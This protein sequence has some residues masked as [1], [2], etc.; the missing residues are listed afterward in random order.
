[1]LGGCEIEPEAADLKEWGAGASG[2]EGAEA[3]RGSGGGAEDADSGLL[4]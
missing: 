4:P 1:M 2:G 3:A